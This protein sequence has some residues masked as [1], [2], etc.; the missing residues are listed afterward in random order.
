MLKR[1]LIKLNR[2]GCSDI[3]LI[4]GCWS[5]SWSKSEFAPSWMEEL[6]WSWTWFMSTSGK[7]STHISVSGNM[8]WYRSLNTNRFSVS[9]SKNAFFSKA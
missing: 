4:Q 5:K 2:N 7:N 9:G 8:Y 1:K 3:N 6:I